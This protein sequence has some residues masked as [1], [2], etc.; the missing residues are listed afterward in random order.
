LQGAVNPV[1]PDRHL[2]LER[3]DFFMC[4][5]FR[6]LVLRLGIGL[7]AFLLGVTAAWALGG[8]NPFQSSSSERY[9]RHH[10]SYRGSDVQP[11]NADMPTFYRKR[12]SC[13]ARGALGEIPT[14]PPA[15]FADAPLPPSPPSVSR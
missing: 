6:R 14:P 9:Y 8:F 3:K 11:E 7:L 13:K 10:R 1:A 15:P 12:E 4:T 5:R 2:C